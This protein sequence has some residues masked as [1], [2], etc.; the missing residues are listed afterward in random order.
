M[1]CLKIYFKS[2]LKSKLVSVTSSNKAFLPGH[3]ERLKMLES[4]KDKVDAFWFNSIMAL[5]NKMIR[6]ERKFES[7]KDYAFS[8]AIENLES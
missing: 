6:D 8:I 2:T 3:R 7:L 4:V 1:K 5:H